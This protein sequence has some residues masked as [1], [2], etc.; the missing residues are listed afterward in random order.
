MTRTKETW[1]IGTGL[2][3][4]RQESTHN[5]LHKICLE[6]NLTKQCLGKSRSQQIR[7]RKRE[8][9]EIYEH[10]PPR[11]RHRTQGSA[12]GLGPALACASRA[13]R[14]GDRIHFCL[15]PSCISHRR[16][17]HLCRRRLPQNSGPHRR[18][19]GSG[20]RAY[21]LGDGQFIS[22]LYRLARRPRERSAPPSLEFRVAL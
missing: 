16:P 10:P 9:P 15:E 8:L 14:G 22:Q 20:G 19:S 7:H 11:Q 4:S 5:P 13:G 1:T 21:S 12:S 2:F 17:S 3:F 6:P 18:L